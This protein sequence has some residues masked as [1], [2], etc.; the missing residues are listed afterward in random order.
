MA[1]MVTMKISKGK[2]EEKSKENC[3]EFLNG[4]EFATVTF[5]S[6]PHISNL[7]KLYKSK[8]Y[9]KYFEFFHENKDNSVCA[10]IPVSWVQIN[11]PNK[12]NLTDE[13]RKALADRLK[14]GREEKE[15]KGL[16]E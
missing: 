13:Q 8:R 2:V 10:K 12:K 16:E 6:R 15:K 4:K 3:V 9:G 11:P 1:K 5:N 14:K 7:K